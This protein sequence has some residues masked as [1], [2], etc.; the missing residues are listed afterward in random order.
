MHSFKDELPYDAGIAEANPLQPLADM[1]PD[2]RFEEIGKL[3][4]ESMGVGAGADQWKL[5]GLAVLLYCL[6]DMPD[7]NAGYNVPL[8]AAVQALQAA[9]HLGASRKRR[10]KTPISDDGQ[11]RDAIPRGVSPEYSI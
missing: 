7:V 10:K 6:E 11:P 8:I 9:Y 5:D 4:D 3:F 2:E 1:F